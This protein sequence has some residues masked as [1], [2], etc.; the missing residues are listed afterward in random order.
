MTLPLRAVS[1]AAILAALAALTAC[2]SHPNSSETTAT[3]T[4]STPA[5]VDATAAAAVP[6]GTKKDI[7]GSW[8]L[9]G[10]AAGTRY[11]SF[12]FHP[13][14]SG[15]LGHVTAVVQ[16]SN[17]PK[18]VTQ[19]LTWYFLKTGQ[20]VLRNPKADMSMVI[21]AFQT[22]DANTMDIQCGQ[23]GVLHMVRK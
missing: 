17:M 19:Q 21:C 1:T 5:A 23:T 9:V 2:S 8:K 18:P 22:Q 15:T 6:S 4:Q 13:Y 11:Y 7:I 14:A 10:D 16:D 20:V 12:N 3:T